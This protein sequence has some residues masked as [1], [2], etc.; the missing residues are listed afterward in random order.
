M[1]LGVVGGGSLDWRR[2]RTLSRSRMPAPPGWTA[3]WGAALVD[4]AYAAADVPIV[5]APP[6]RGHT[7]FDPWRRVITVSPDPLAPA[8]QLSWDVW[9]EVAHSRQPLWWLR[10]VSLVSLAA[11]V[12]FPLWL[13]AAPLSLA[14]GGVVLWSTM[15]VGLITCLE[16]R[17][18]LA[19]APAWGPALSA[20]AA[21]LAR[22]RVP[23]HAFG[24]F[25]WT[26]WIPLMM[27]WVAHWWW[28]ALVLRRV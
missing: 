26:A 11:Y 20:W 5:S 9:H 21:A 16:R 24:A 28:V 12:L 14:V 22:R 2:L 3:A 7:A 17:A 4:R 8:W 25:L 6:G 27:G 13:V 23:A 18:D 15:V 10:G 19:A 1:G